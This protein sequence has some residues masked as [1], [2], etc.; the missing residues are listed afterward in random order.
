MSGT[1][2]SKEVHNE[3]VKALAGLINSAAGSC[4]TLGF[5]AP[6]AGAFWG[7]FADTQFVSLKAL[8]LGFFVWIGAAV[9]LHLQ[10]RRVLKGIRTT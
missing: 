8:V 10:S 7:Y 5:I 4:I 2:T 6:A 9:L 1:I 3:Q